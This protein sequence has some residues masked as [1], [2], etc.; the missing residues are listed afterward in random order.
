MDEE[1]LPTPDDV[2]LALIQRGYNVE[3]YTDYCTI[4]M[5]QCHVYSGMHAYVY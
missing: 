1:L 4:N 2:G 5:G 3:C